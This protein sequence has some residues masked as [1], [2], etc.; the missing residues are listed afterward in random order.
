MWSCRQNLYVKKNCL[1][2]NNNAYIENVV[3]SSNRKELLRH[4]LGVNVGSGWNRGNAAIVSVEI[5]THTSKIGAYESEKKSALEEKQWKWLTCRQRKGCKN[6]CVPGKRSE[7]NGI[8]S[9]GGWQESTHVQRN[10]GN[11]GLEKVTF[12]RALQFFRHV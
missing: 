5:T 2:R 8:C 7:S 9:V 3:M 6:N 10:D 4:K 12:L 1:R 11:G